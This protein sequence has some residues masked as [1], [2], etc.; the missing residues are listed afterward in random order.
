MDAQA[1]AVLWEPVGVEVQDG[2][3]PPC[4]VTGEGVPVGHVANPSLAE[5]RELHGEAREPEPGLFVELEAHCVEE[6]PEPWQR[7]AISLPGGAVAAKL[8][9]ELCGAPN[10][11]LPEGTLTVHA[12]HL[13]RAGNH[14]CVGE[15]VVAHNGLAFPQRADIRVGEI[16]GFVH[17][18][19][20]SQSVCS[21]MLDPRAVVAN[22]PNGRGGPARG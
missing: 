22:A 13:C 1:A 16:E 21:A 11:C 14:R 6:L 2:G 4:A 20:V 8:G 7:H 3:G 9:V 18:S 19:R 17:P 5:D 15:D 12:R 10:A